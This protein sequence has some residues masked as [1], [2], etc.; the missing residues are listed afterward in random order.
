MTV[1]QSFF[2]SHQIPFQR[3]RSWNVTLAVLDKKITDVCLKIIKNISLAAAGSV[4]FV[5]GVFIGVSS[6]PL[7]F[8]G[9]A[10]CL[11]SLASFIRS[12]MMR[13]FDPT[14]LEVYK[15]DALGDLKIFEELEKL[16]V[17]SD[18]ITQE[19][20][21]RP[22]SWLLETH[23]LE[24]ILKYEILSPE[25]FKKAYHLEIEHKSVKDQLDFFVKFARELKRFRNYETVYTEL[26]EN[27]KGNL[28]RSIDTA[29]EE[30]CLVDNYKA[31]YQKDL[32]LTDLLELCEKAIRADVLEKDLKQFLKLKKEFLQS[33]SSIH[34]QAGLPGKKYHQ[35]YRK[36][37]ENYQER[38]TQYQGHDHHDFIERKQ[39]AYF[40]NI[41]AIIHQKQ[42]QEQPLDEA[43]K[44][45]QGTPDT[46]G[47]LRATQKAARTDIDN[48]FKFKLDALSKVH[49]DQE[50][51]DKSQKLKGIFDELSIPKAPQYDSDKAL[52]FTDFKERYSDLQ[53]FLCEFL[54]AP[55][56]SAV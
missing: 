23:P 38:V 52:N 24:A 25:D 43:L 9:G 45:L 41:K 54:F 48:D 17:I 19:K 22:L 28:S 21:I 27:L 56:D 34:D 50:F 32:E 39:R 42:T 1:Q 33:I 49:F 8:V 37:Y 46:V 13:Y 7:T 18:P 5:V 14:R 35:S 31:F 44:K 26:K 6:I 20:F 10:L 4:T 2:A 53:V 40:E 3:K 16:G 11:A 47:L 36:V 15:Q 55:Q 51:Q 30:D 12:C 29:L